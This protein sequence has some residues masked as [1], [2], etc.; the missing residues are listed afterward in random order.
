[1]AYSIYTFYSNKV[2]RKKK[3]FTVCVF[4]HFYLIKFNL[5]IFKNFRA[6]FWRNFV[7]FIKNTLFCY[8]IFGPFIF[9]FI[10]VVCSICIFI[11]N[12]LCS[13]VLVLKIWSYLIYITSYSLY[14]WSTLSKGF[15]KNIQ[16]T[17]LQN[18]FLHCIFSYFF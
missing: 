13:T 2:H 17:V 14:I 3:L 7:F 11:L 16:Y 5:C 18:Y 12:Q 1:M 6:Y 15:M 4:L 10:V 8:Y 9:P